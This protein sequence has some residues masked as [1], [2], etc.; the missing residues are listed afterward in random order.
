MQE[1]SANLEPKL[2]PFQAV[3]KNILFAIL[4][5]FLTFGIYYFFWQAHQMRAWNQLLG[6]QKYGFWKWL[7]LSI[8]TLGL[9]HIYH[10]YIMGADMLEIQQRFNKPLSNGLP[11]ISV[12]LAVFGVPIISD[13]IQQ[14]ELHR[15]Y[16]VA[17]IES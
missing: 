7:I 6:F 17:S 12:L 2:P 13:A 1:S 5:T 4:L 3:H 16:E 9:Y 14:Y 15:L 10:E 11:L 8:L